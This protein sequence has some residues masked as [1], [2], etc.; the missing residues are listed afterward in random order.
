MN[1][2]LISL[3]ISIWEFDDNVAVV[4]Q[5][6]VQDDETDVWA[7]PDDVAASDV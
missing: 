3:S 2:A 1:E 6:V 5:V 7:E 4:A